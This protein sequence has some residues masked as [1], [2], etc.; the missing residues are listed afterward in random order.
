MPELFSNSA[1]RKA[2]VIEYPR[3]NQRGTFCKPKF[4]YFTDISLINHM[5]IQKCFGHPSTMLAH[6]VF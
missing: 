3:S 1:L 6:L 5:G 4:Y 2:V